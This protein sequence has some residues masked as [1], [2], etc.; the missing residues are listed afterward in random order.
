VLLGAIGVERSGEPGGVG[1]FMY[2]SSTL[3]QCFG[4]SSE[5]FQGFDGP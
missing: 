4:M 3:G 2:L 5:M 1:V